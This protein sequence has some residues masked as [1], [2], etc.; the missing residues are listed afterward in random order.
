[1]NLS[2]TDEDPAWDKTSYYYVRIEQERFAGGY[3]A[4]AWASP[5]WIDIRR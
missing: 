5:M 2:W 1:M 3:G 4:L